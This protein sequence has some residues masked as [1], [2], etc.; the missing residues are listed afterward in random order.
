MSYSFRP[1]DGAT[2][3]LT[4]GIQ[5]P[6]GS[7]FPNNN[8]ISSGSLNSMFV[9]MS[10]KQSNEVQ[11]LSSEY[12]PRSVTASPATLPGHGT[13]SAHAS[14]PSSPSGSTN[15]IDF[16]SPQRPMGGGGGG[17]GIPGG[18]FRHI[19]QVGGGG[20]GGG[21]GYIDY[22][23]QQQPHYPRPR[24]QQNVRNNN[25]NNNGGVGSSYMSQTQQQPQ[26]NPDYYNFD[27]NYPSAQQYPKY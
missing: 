13:E 16:T 22:S 25:N 8:S 3:A 9:P 14:I 6:S 26:P 5:S 10:P 19:N 11:N 12:G 15:N 20:G 23:H 21:G 24:N 18:S 2:R 17:G 27:G 7:G 1:S 4:T